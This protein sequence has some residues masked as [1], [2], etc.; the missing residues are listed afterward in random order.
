MTERRVPTLLTGKN[1]TPQ[2]ELSPGLSVALFYQIQ[3]L[4]DED[5]ARELESVEDGTVEEEVEGPDVRDA[6]VSDGNFLETD[7]EL[8]SALGLQSQ[9]HLDSSV[10]HL[11]TLP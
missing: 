4:S 11:T 1:K 3:E 5:P 6:G 9:Q 7:T 8:S 10:S 2:R